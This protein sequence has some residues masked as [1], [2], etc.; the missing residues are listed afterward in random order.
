MLDS[1]I[2]KLFEVDTSRLNE[3]MKRNQNRF[4]QDFSFQLNSLEFKSLKSQNAI[5]NS[6]RGGRR[7]LPYVY[8]EQGIIA[9][10]GVLKSDVADQ[11]YIWISWVSYI[12]IQKLLINWKEWYYEQFISR[13]IRHKRGNR[14]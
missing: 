8:T 7:K 14:N 6:G 2:A 3:Q 9:L 5:S 1:D 10:A 11:M 13:T 12:F 4:P